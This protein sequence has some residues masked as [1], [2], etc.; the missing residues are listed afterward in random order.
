M[1]Y[2]MNHRADWNDHWSLE[3]DLSPAE[4]LK[5]DTDEAWDLWQC[6]RLRSVSSVAVVTSFNFES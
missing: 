2:V 3:D 5:R 1:K 6:E 4:W